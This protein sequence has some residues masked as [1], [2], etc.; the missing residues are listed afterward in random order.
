MSF[1]RQAFTPVF[2]SLAQPTVELGDHSMLIGGSII[3][4]K[5][6]EAWPICATCT[7]PLI[8][9]VQINVSSKN[10]PEAFSSLFPSPIAQN[11][12]TTMVQLFVCPEEDCYDHSTLYSTDT[13]S[14]IVRVAAV[15]TVVHPGGAPRAKIEQGPGFLPARLVETWAA[16]KEETLHDELLWD[17]N[18]SEEFYAL[19]EPEPGL[20]LLGHA[21]RGTWRFP[22]PTGH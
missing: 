15:S 6:D 2:V 22:Q 21:V 12:L 16:G 9:L 13:R 5:P 10:T 11:G 4:L 14:W 8:P 19:H 20:K 7:H 18:D 17:Q 1:L 3:Y